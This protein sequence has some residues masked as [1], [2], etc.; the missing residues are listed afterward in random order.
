MTYVPQPWE[1]PMAGSEVDHL[2][3]SLDRLRATFAWK[4]RGLDSAGLSFRLPSS[5]LSIGRLLKHLS[6]AEDE[7]FSRK[8]WGEA[9]SELWR[10]APWDT[11]PDWDFKSADH[12]T[13][14]YLYAL[15]TDTVARSRAS[16][17]R[18]LAIDGLGHEAHLGWAGQHVS[19]RR[20]LFDL[21]EEY[22]RHTGHADLLREAI[23]GVVGEDPPSDMSW[24]NPFT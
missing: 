4:A 9:P 21:V 23:D 17:Q 1:P 10:S 22:G 11:D 5:S 8:L 3:A 15:W 16:V 12:D 13:P 24:P 2:L 19:L 20:L 6:R 14:E 18:A 7:M